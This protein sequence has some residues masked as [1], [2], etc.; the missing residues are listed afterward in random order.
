MSA[1]RTWLAALGL[2]ALTA[3]TDAPAPIDAPE[4]FQVVS[5][6]ARFLAQGEGNIP[7]KWLEMPD[8]RFPSAALGLTKARASR[9]IAQALMQ[10]LGPAS[11]GGTRAVTVRYDI[12][13][14]SLPSRDPTT[15]TGVT[16]YSN[17]VGWLQFIDSATGQVLVS[18]VAF[19][20]NPLL[21]LSYGEIRARA[22][23]RQNPVQGYDELLGMVRAQSPAFLPRP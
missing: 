14:L 10:G 23:L 13:A 3:C 20:V 7:L 5:T 22:R 12:Y 1:L 8:R 19:Q 16:T 15:A 21:G 17:L 18:D 9:D 4:T 11:R 2:L 6:S